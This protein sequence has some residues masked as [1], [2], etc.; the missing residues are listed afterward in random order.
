MKRFILSIAALCCCAGLRA[1]GD[2]RIYRTEF[3]PFDT[4]EEADGRTRRNIDKYR[5]FE[6]RLLSDGEEILGLGETVTIPN[7]W[8]DSFVYLH[9]EN[10]G[11]A[12]TLSV[13]G[14]PAAVVEDPFSPADFDLSPYL[15]QGENLLLLELHKSTAPQLQERLSAAPVKPFT[16]S[17][18]FAQEKRSIYDFNVA[19]EP[20]PTRKF[21]MLN[22]EVV[23]RNG[24]NYDEP[25]TV[26]FDIYDPSGK[27]LDYSVNE[28][29]VPGR[30]LDTVRFTP[31]IYHTNANAWGGKDSSP[32]YRVML[33]TK[34]NGTF[35]EYIPFRVGF[36][37]PRLTAEGTLRYF[38]GE[39]PVVARRCDAGADAKVTR[40]QLETLKR[41]GVNLL[42]P[43]QPQPDWFY[44]LCDGLGLA[45]IDCAGIDAPSRRDDRRVGGTPSNDPALTAEYL[46]R[47]RAMYHRCRT[48]TCIVGFAPG[49]A[50][51]N[52]YNMYKAYQWLKA[53]ESLRPIVYS[54]AD[55]E[56]NTDFEFA[57]PESGRN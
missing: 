34:R 5:T 18:L 49:N 27:L 30:S 19:L 25:I 43:S 10:A 15:R 16:N 29:T 45:V 44:A 17:Y 3:I 24:Y 2:A 7:A 4:R 8:L 37:R 32:L 14:R 23:L 31:C 40:E 46:D 1:Q 6:P 52:G 39:R 36:A 21:G 50:S 9:I 56:W 28:F 22:L 42:L 41:Q 51:G 35:R 48:H 26:G 11:T 13:N 12:Y 54:D 53:A 38:D 20:D 57:L 33:Y 47:V 55:G